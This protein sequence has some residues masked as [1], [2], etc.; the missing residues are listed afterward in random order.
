MKQPNNYLRTLMLTNVFP[1]PLSEVI[2]KSAE[3][4]DA[5]H[6]AELYKFLVQEKVTLLALYDED[7]SPQ[8]LSS[9]DRTLEILKQRYNR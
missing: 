9:V 6:F 2:V 8:Q 7:M 4:L 1:V 3:N 5:A